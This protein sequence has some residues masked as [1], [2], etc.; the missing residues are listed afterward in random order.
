METAARLRPRSSPACAATVSATGIS[1]DEIA[2]ETQVRRELSRRVRAE[3]SRRTGPSG[4]YAR[5]WIRAYASAVGLDPDRHRGRVLPAVP[6][7]R[8]PRAADDGAR[9][10]PSWPSA[11]DYRD[12]FP[13]ARPAPAG[14]GR[15]AGRRARVRW[16]PAPAS[17]CASPPKPWPISTRTLL[18]RVPA[19]PLLSE[20]PPRSGSV[21]AACASARFAAIIPPSFAKEAHDCSPRRLP[22]RHPGWP[23]PRLPS[24]RRRAHCER[25]TSS[26]SRRRRRSWTRCSSWPRSPRTT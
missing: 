9:W 21:A 4:L 14:A 19:P 26:S 6:A 10:R 16:P 17:R 8:P 24:R 22:A 18:A 2:A 1:L 23:G 12:E 7:G 11:S 20:A 5:A 15:P 13:H 25:R 3:R